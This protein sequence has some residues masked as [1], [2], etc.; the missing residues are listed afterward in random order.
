MKE[1]K[2]KITSSGYCETECKYFPKVKVGSLACQ[3]C[4]YNGGEKSLGLYR[5]IVKC[6]YIELK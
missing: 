5:G 2:Y 1:I 4:K 6:K 3:K